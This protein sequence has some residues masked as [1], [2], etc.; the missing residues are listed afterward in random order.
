VGAIRRR[1]LDDPDLVH[2]LPLATIRVVRIGSHTLGYGIEQP[3]WRWSTHMGPTEALA[4]PSEIL[5][6][7]V[8]VGLADGSGLAFEGL[9]QREVKGLDRPI[10]VH[11]LA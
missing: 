10:E 5:A 3:G 1:R 8:T 4:G 9:G 7:S 2:D 11:R 6:S